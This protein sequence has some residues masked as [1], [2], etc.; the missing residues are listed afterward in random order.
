MIVFYADLWDDSSREKC[1]KSV[2][3]TK[4]IKQENLYKKFPDKD[5][6]Y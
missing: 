2:H 1:C 6:Y 5:F 4:A 3:A